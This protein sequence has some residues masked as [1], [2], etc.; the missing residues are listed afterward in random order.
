MPTIHKV[1]FW[2]LHLYGRLEYLANDLAADLGVSGNVSNL[3]DSV[4]ALLVRLEVCIHSESDGV[5]LGH[6]ANVFRDKGS[7]LDLRKV[8]TFRCNL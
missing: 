7:S 6:L 2:E 4:C 8:L 3:V 5:V 1:A